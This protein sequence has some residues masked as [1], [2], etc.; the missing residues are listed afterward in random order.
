MNGLISSDKDKG[1]KTLKE[2]AQ[3][4]HFIMINITETWLNED[5]KGDE[6]I[7]GYNIFR[8]DRE[9]AIR[10]GVAT[11]INDRVE[12]KM[13]R[14]YSISNCE[15]LMT[16]IEEL[17]AINVLIYRP[18]TTN[19]ETFNKILKEIADMYKTLEKPDPTIIISGDFNF[20]LVEW[21]KNNMEGCT[22][23]YKSHTNA[24]TS[25]KN[26][27]ENLMLLCEEMCMEQ[28]I[29]TPNRERNVLDLCF[30][31]EAK[32][33]KNIDTTKSAI[34]DHNRIEISTN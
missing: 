27:F 18:P 21:E 28:I 24:C 16:K 2:Y 14:K 23:T 11:Y 26:Q 3:T 33:I 12:A 30:T 20:P 19:E 31:N 5:I 10:G 9:N 34:S 13:I 15:M 4:K 25:D 1:M 6:K 22:W 32:L 29:N 17:N 7:D 8:A